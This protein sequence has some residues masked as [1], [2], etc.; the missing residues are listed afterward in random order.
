[1]LVLAAAVHNL[2]LW[3]LMVYC[4]SPISP[5]TLS[6]F[7]SLPLPSPP[8]PLISSRAQ[9]AA[10][11]LTRGR[12]PGRM[13]GRCLHGR[14]CSTV[15]SSPTSVKSLRS[16]FRLHCFF[17]L[18]WIQKSIFECSYRWSCS[19]IKGV[20]S[21]LDR[22]KINC[23]QDLTNTFFSPD[24]F[25]IHINWYKLT[26]GHYHPS[27]SCFPI[28][29]TLQIMSCLIICKTSYRL[30]LDMIGEWIQLYFFS[31]VDCFIQMIFGP[32]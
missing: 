4:A 16:R 32:Q 23:S 5:L 15:P 24:F 26:C 27:K 31:F 6:L 7:V 25:K 18:K 22:R 2:R 21:Q 29:W 20:F 8:P 12:S 30:I 11:V 10:G 9:E 1:M 3:S 13:R 14:S 19:K 17:S 28:H